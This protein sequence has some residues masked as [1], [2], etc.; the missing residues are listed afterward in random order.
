MKPI[1]EQ[2]KQALKSRSGLSEQ[3]QYG[4]ED[5]ATDLMDEL[6]SDGSLSNVGISLEGLNSQQQR[7]LEDALVNALMSVGEKYNMVF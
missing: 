7:A 1:Q 4:I 5:I 3:S 6:M 2:F